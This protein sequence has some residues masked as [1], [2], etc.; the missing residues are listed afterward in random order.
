MIR[1]LPKPGVLLIILILV[2]SACSTESPGET[3][4][5]MVFL[6]DIMAHD[7][8]YN[9]RGYDRIYEH[10][11]PLFTE[12][13]F[14]FGQLEFVVD[15]DRPQ[16]SYPRFNVH[17]AYVVAAVEA[18]IRVFSLANNHSTDFGEAGMRATGTSMQTI[19]REHDIWFN[20]LRSD[21]DDED[22][23]NDRFEITVLPHAGLR[24]GFLALTRLLND[25]S[26]GN[27]VHYV[28]RGNADAAG[29]FMESLSHL[30]QG[31]D[32]FVLSVHDGIEYLQDVD[33]ETLSFMTAA[34]DAG[35]DIVWGNHPHVLQQWFLHERT[36]AGPALI[37]PSL[38]NFVS[39]QTWPLGPDR[40]E[41][42]W[43]ATGDSAVV[44]VIM[45]G[46]AAGVAIERVVADLVTHYKDPGGGVSVRPL[47]GLAGHAVLSDEWREFYRIR[48]E[49]NSHFDLLHERARDQAN[50]R[51]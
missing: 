48:A 37:M 21:A 51:E 19:A 17:P 22:Y 4:L 18:G 40:A 41:A 6:G 11:L 47:D 49:R 31:F 10:V 14:V 9:M 16:S 34:A 32:V 8:N 13:E 20:G 38:G 45:R 1:F 26:A 30:T 5:R 7:V 12:A 39:G 2:S 46:T 25:S 43:A 24:I 15:P 50:T 23:A 27:A 3:E 35:A 44:R 36:G 28:P 42:A 33:G 29:A